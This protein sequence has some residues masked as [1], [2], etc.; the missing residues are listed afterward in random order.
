MSIFFIGGLG[1]IG[2]HSETSFSVKNQTGKQIVNLGTG[3]PNSALEMNSYFESFT[4]QCIP[5]QMGK[6]R[7]S[8]LP[9]Y[10]AC[11]DRAKTILG[12]Q[13]PHRLEEIYKSSRC[14]REQPQELRTLI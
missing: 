8:N 7:A 4:G 9:I 10:F 6:R 11:A 12:S 13:V 2:N 1:F 14:C 3:L 5:V